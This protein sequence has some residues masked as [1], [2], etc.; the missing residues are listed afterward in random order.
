MNAVNLILLTKRFR[1][2]NLEVLYLPTLFN[3][4][5]NEEIFRQ[6]R[7]MGTVHFTRINFTLL[8]LFHL[9]GRVELQ[10]EI[11]YFKLADKDV[12]FPRNK[13]NQ[14][15]LNKHKLPNDK[16]IE[17]IINESKSAALKDALMFGINI[18]VEEIRSCELL[19]LDNLQ[20]H[21]HILSDETRSMNDSDE[22]NV[23]SD[24]E[25][26]RS[27]MIKITLANGTKKTI[28]KSTYLWTLT[29]SRK[30]LSSDRLKRVQG[31]KMDEKLTKSTKPATRRLV[32]K[33]ENNCS[34]PILTLSKC[35][36]LQIGDWCIFQIE[37]D[38]APVFVLG[39]ILS[40]KYIEGRTRKERQ[41]SWEFAPVTAEKNV[42]PRGIEVLASWFKIGSSANLFPIDKV[43]SFYIDIKKYVF[44]LNCSNIKLDQSSGCLTFTSDVEV[45]K[46]F[47]EQLSR[48]ALK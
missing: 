1:D 14:A 7:S 15:Q 40:F 21:K 46:Q 13:L 20:S 39:N 23:E 18:S 10:N 44:N 37:K 32:F 5:P 25:K 33:K 47:Q 43:N 16:E 30:H 34:G 17:E 29:D 4:Q 45:L 28:R 27:S 31:V 35:E 38:K 48:F 2:E 9:V 26:V 19:N 42:K 8:E 41:Y 12:R 22:E 11:V 3:S 24:D 36:S 6:F